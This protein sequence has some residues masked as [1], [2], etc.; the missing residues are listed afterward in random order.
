MK[1]RYIIHTVGPVWYGG[2]AGERQVLSSCYR[3]CLL[4]ADALGLETI[5]FP[6]ISTGVYGYPLHEAAQVTLDALMQHRAV[7]LLQATVFLF[8]EDVYRAYSTEFRLRDGAE[9]VG[10]G[11]LRG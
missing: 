10:G 8:S 11:P 6:A 4:L 2:D 7:T 5:A 1:A 3:S 9:P